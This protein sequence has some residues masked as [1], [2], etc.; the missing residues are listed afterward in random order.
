MPLAT[1]M[2]K[3]LG[4]HIINICVD[5]ADDSFNV[6]CRSECAK[7]LTIDNNVA[8]VNCRTEGAAESGSYEKKQWI[9]QTKHRRPSQVSLVATE[10]I[11]RSTV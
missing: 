11:E 6:V 8:C 10:A 1:T 9:L 5:V 2:L 3:A 7:S 4:S